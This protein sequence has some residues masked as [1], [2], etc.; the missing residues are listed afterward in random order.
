M[1]LSK[2]E[3][4]KLWTCP[5]CGRSF[6]RQNQSHS[7]KLY[8]LQKHFEGRE[9]GK[10]LYDKLILAIRKEIASFNIQSL[11]CCIHLDSSITFAAVK[12]AKH[13]IELHFGS[14]HKVSSK[15]FKKVLQLSANRYLYYV[16]IC[17]AE[18]IDAE[19]LGW[20]KEAYVK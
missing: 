9:E 18:E 17:S 5:K 2:I 14:R 6:E 20:I 16:D 4:E 1:Q 11:E 12:I 7:C 13:K 19:L 10:L 15:R 8:P 3:K